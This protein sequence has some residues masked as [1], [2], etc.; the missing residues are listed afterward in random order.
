MDEPGAD[1]APPLQP[2]PNPVR[3]IH[4]WCK[5]AKAEAPEF[6]VVRVA[7]PDDPL[8]PET[9]GFICNLKV[10]GTLDEDTGERIEDLVSCEAEGLGGCMHMTLRWR[11]GSRCCDLIAPPRA[12]SAMHQLSRVAA[13][14]DAAGRRCVRHPAPVYPRK[15]CSKAVG[16]KGLPN[17]SRARNSTRLSRHT[18]RTRHRPHPFTNPA[19]PVAQFLNQHMALRTPHQFTPHHNAP[20]RSA[21]DHTNDPPGAT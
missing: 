17:R 16:A 14:P 20:R 19:A 10:P 12:S 2:H 4:T 11:E 21:R 18:R 15:W 8:I 3:Q 9:P 1:G 6:E 7:C 13:S 5:R